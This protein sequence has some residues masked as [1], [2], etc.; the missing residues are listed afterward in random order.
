LS[1]SSAGQ[2]SQRFTGTT[3]CARTVP[4][5][6]RSFLRTETG[7]AALLLAAATAALVWANVAARSYGTVWSTQ[8]SIHLGGSSVS[9]DLRG[10]VNSGVMTFFFFVIGLEA[11][12]EFDLGELRERRRTRAAAARRT[13]WRGRERRRLSRVQRGSAVGARLGYRDVDR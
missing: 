5:P 6:L 11:H 2:V 3:A 1:A 12:R 4:T 13:R 9:L 10:W 8:L 7:G